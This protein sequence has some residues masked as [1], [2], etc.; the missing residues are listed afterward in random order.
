MIVYIAGVVLLIIGVLLFMQISGKSSPSAT[1]DAAAGAGTDQSDAEKERQAAEAAKQREAQLKNLTVPMSLPEVKIYFGSQTGTAEKLAGML[2]EEAHLMG[3]P[4]LDVIDFNN[5]TEEDFSSHK[6]V[7][8]V[9]ATHYEGDPCDNTRNF[10]KWFKKILKDKKKIFEG[11]KFAVFGLGD[12]S[13]E[14]YN[15]M[16][17][18]FDEGLEKLGAE[19]LH[20]LGDGNAETFSTEDDFAKWKENLWPKIFEHY[21]QFDTTEQKEKALVRR[22]SSI[23]HQGVEGKADALPWIIDD[24]GIALAD[25]DIEPQYD[26]NMRNYTSSIEIPVKDV[27]ELRQ[28]AGYGASTLEVVFDLS[29]TGLTYKTA[30]NFAIYPVNNTANVEEFAAQHEIDL[31]KKFTFTRNFEFRGRPPKM[32]FPTNGE[33][34]FRDALTKFVDLTGA[35][36][37]KTL[38]ALIPLCESAEDKKV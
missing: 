37:K 35:M 29:G 33:I 13:Y 7:I 12:T 14:Q 24:S 4:K 25:N 3:V 22:Q 16:G 30:A 1:T 2:D 23:L 27:R 20:D 32:P 26:M 34:S 18:Q 6:L 21:A 10:Y 19:R 11:M 31:N 9:I 36:T 28:K 17:K 15:E 5:F 8:V 38:T